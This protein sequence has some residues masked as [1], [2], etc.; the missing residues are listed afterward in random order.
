MSVSIDNDIKLFLPNEYEYMIYG[1]NFLFSKRFY[2][3]AKR[4]NSIKRIDYKKNS[5]SIQK[6]NNLI[7]YYNTKTFI[8]TSKL[9]SELKEDER[10]IFT[11]FIT[12]S[13]I[14]FILI[15]IGPPTKFTTY[16]KSI[17]NKN[18]D[19]IYSFSRFLTYVISNIQDNPF[20]SSN[21]DKEKEETYLADDLIDE[22]L[23][24]IKCTGIIKASK[25][26]KTYNEIL[27]YVT[28]QSKAALNLIYRK[29]PYEIVKNKSV[30]EW[31][32][33]L[34]TC[35][36]K[37]I[38]NK[39][40][41][42]IDI[43]VPVPETGKTYAQGISSSISKPYVEALYKKTEIGRSLDIQDKNIRKQFIKNKLGLI[44]SLVKDKVVG[45][46][47][48]AIFTGITLKEVSLLLKE[49]K[50]KKIYFLIPSPE[51]SN[52]CTYNMQPSRE[53][54]SEKF[55]KKELKAYF[56][57]DGIF[58]QEYNLFKTIMN[59]SGF[60]YLCCFKK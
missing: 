50:A 40:C 9:L 35:L 24:N 29:K 41:D 5:N 10:K 7:K 15:E 25:S 12:N 49:A 28:Q 14:K 43:I 44:K 26:S 45:I 32:M 19:L 17:L 13:N 39:I 23:A 59:E 1:G 2:E 52:K 55:N 31:R 6:I 56:N 46:V 54:L 57:I 34:G 53:F 47:D 51:C 60:N 21:L 16:I 37:N 27:N 30:A 33:T 18:K 36:G 22:L 11:S 48:E 38:N 42:E 8:F 58:F 20:Y 3:I 4:T